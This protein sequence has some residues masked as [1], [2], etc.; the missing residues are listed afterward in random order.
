MIGFLTYNS[1][2]EFYDIKNG[3]RAHVLSDVGSV[4]P[5]F[6]SFLVDP[7]THM[8]EIE[9]F[10]QLIPYLCGDDELETETIL[11]PVIEAALQTCMV[12][13]N[14][15]FPDCDEKFIREQLNSETKPIPVGKVYLF[16]CTLPTYGSDATTPGR[17]KPR[18]TTA[19]GL[20]PLSF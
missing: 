15:W 16:H 11:G 14:N 10:L 20:F 1:K 13:I 2:I 4:F 19:P 18:W 12:D 7:V 5:A 8:A 6:T 3:G 17:L 9:R